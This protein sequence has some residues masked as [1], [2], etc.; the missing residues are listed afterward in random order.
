M[1]AP[2]ITIKSVTRAKISNKAGM[3]TCEVAFA[4]EQPL[5]DWEA[6]ADGAGVGQGLL[7]GK[8]VI[9]PIPQT[10][11]E[12][13]AMGY[14]QDA[15]DALNQTWDEL[16]DRTILQVDTDETFLVENEELTQGDKT[17]RINVY[18]KNAAGEWT[19]YG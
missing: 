2:I 12:L 17:Y 7:V 16:D 5:V 14:T 1:S 11:N 19:T 6:R 18:G 8:A 4:S 9:D 3:D 15:F 10:W 13:D